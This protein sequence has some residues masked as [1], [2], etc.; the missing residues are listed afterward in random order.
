MERRTPDRP[1]AR[2]RTSRTAYFVLAEG[3]E[4]V[5]STLEDDKTI[6]F[7]EWA[8]T[9][10]ATPGHSRDHFAFRLRK[11]G[12]VKG[13]EFLYC[14]DAFR[15]P[16]KLWTPFTTGWDHWTD[17]GLKPIAESLRKMAALKPEYLGPAHGPVVTKDAAPALFDTARTVEEVGFLKSFERFTDRLGNAP[18]YK[19][20]VPKEQV[21][22]AGEKPWARVPDHLWIT[23]NT[24]RSSRRTTRPCSCSTRGARGARVIDV[25][26]R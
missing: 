11:V 9:P 21:A 17:V 19:F 24:Y 15:T 12:D 22:S 18:D 26:V 23:G 2:V 1:E 7:G 14:G 4:G 8:I 16:G 10:V 25:S 13:P 5:D 3:V 20:L 6:V